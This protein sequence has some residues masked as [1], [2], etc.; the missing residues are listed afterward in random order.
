MAL[1]QHPTRF[2]SPNGAKL[3]RSP[4][5]SRP[6]LRREDLVRQLS[7]LRVIDAIDPALRLNDDATVLLDGIDTSV[8]TG[9]VPLHLGG[10]HGDATIH[11]VTGVDLQRGLVRRDL[12]ADSGS[13]GV[14]SED[15]DEGVRCEG[16]RT[17]DDEA[18]VV[19]DAVRAAD[20]LGVLQ[21]LANEFASS[22]VHAGVRG[23]GDV[24]DGAVG[25][26]DAVRANVTLGQGQLEEGIVQ[27]GGLLEGVQVPVDVVREHDRR[28]LGQGERDQ[29]GS[30]LGE[31]G[32]VLWSA[33]G[34]DA[35]R[36][37]GDHVSGETFQGLVEEGKRNCVL[38]GRSH[39]PIALVVAN[40]SS[41]KGVRAVVLVR[42][43]MI[44]LA[45]D[46]ESAVLDSIGIAT[47]DGTKVGVLAFSVLD[48][49][50]GVV[51]TDSNVL[52]V[53]IPV[54]DQQGDQTRSIGN[55]FCRDVLCADRVDLEG[56][57]GSLS[58]RVGGRTRWLSLCESRQHGERCWQVLFDVHLQSQGD[59]D[60]HKDQAIYG[61]DTSGEQRAKAVDQPGERAV[62]YVRHPRTAS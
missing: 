29:L 56:V 47:N 10:F 59:G 42:W 27:N 7:P 45:I 17:V 53:T 33:G 46:P 57:D 60:C 2:F 61:E 21:V 3:V 30:Q 26:Q 1:F 24:E 58:C 62:M 23:L 31:T 39:G 5:N 50:M 32:R 11:A 20:P 49:L 4:V 48:V 52:Q 13:A 25:N 38:R 9:L 54:W 15:R 35:E 22:K 8:A 14:E 37:V 51:V 55:E 44:F 34:V 12:H 28:L 16:R 6:R 40:K 43:N 19:A 36:G 41:V 18:V